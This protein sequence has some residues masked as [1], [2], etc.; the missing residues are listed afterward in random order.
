MHTFA[1]TVTESH[2]KSAPH[3]CSMTTESKAEFV[4]NKAVTKGEKV[5]QRG[6]Q[7]SHE[8]SGDVLNAAL[9]RWDD[10]DRNRGHVPMCLYTDE[11]TDEFAS[12]AASRLRYLKQV[13][14]N[15]P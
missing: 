11:I 15:V 8:R 14:S 12:N 7:P 5:E 6:P 13:T 2:A 9:A 1:R 10:D 4:A 3:S